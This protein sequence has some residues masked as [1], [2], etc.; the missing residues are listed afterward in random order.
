VNTY[1][2]PITPDKHSSISATFLDPAYKAD[3]KLGKWHNGWDY[4][5]IPLPDLPFE[6]SARDRGY[7]LRNI[8]PGRV[9]F[10]GRLKFNGGNSGYGRVVKV[11]TEESHRRFIE[12][13]LGFACPVI[14]AVYCHLLQVSVQSGDLLHSGD[15]VGSMGGSGSREDSYPVHLHLSFLRVDTG[16][17]VIPPQGSSGADMVRAMNDFIDPKLILGSSSRRVD[18]S[19]YPSAKH[20]GRL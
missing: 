20:P 15:P 19:D 2:F 13:R 16:A 3:P 7:P 10:A 4:N 8:L 14:D 18:V 1:C 6:G 12:S 11:R 9:I 5:L 17:V